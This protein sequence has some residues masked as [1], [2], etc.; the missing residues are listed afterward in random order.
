GC[1]AGQKS[2]SLNGM[3]FAMNGFGGS[4]GQGNVILIGTSGVPAPFGPLSLR[5]HAF[6]TFPVNV[7]CNSFIGQNLKLVQN[8]APFVVGDPSFCDFGNTIGQNLISVANMAS[9]FSVRISLNT[10]GQN[11]ICIADTPHATGLPSST[12]LP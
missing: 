6:T 1:T 12:L 8:T 3:S 11:L 7:V 4:S 10:I 2:S 9:P 5:I